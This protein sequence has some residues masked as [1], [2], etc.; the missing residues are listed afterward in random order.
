MNIEDDRLA[1]LWERAERGLQDLRIG[2]R[3][4]VRFSDG[5]IVRGEVMPSAGQN[6]VRGEAPTRGAGVAFLLEGGARWA[7]PRSMLSGHVRRLPGEQEGED[8]Q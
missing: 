6:A 5:S 7:M 4:V 2:D 3:V 1:D 8:A